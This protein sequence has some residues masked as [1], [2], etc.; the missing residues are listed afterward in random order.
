MPLIVEGAAEPEPVE[1]GLLVEDAEV[2]CPPEETKTL[3]A[4]KS[5]SKRSKVTKNRQLMPPEA[6]GPIVD[7]APDLFVALTDVSRADTN[8]KVEWVIKM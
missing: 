6:E 7:S 4:V 3:R 5:K 2:K 1:V 8:L